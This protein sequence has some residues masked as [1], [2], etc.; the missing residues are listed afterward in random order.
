MLNRH[1]K[2]TVW[3]NRRR[4]NELSEFRELLVV[5]FN[6]IKF[7][8]ESHISRQARSKINLKVTS[9]RE[10]VRAADVNTDVQWT[11][12]TLSGVW[13]GNNDVLLNF[14]TLDSMN[15]SPQIALDLVERATGVYISNHSKSISRTINPIW[16]VFRSFDWFIRLPF[17]L[18][19]VAGFDTYRLE[20]SVWGLLIKINFVIFS[21]TA[22]LITILSFLGKSESSR[23]MLGALAVRDNHDKILTIL[24]QHEKVTHRMIKL[25]VPYAVYKPSGVP[26]L[27]DAPEHWELRRTKTLLAERSQKGFPDEPLLAATQSRGVVRKEQYE[28]RTVLALKDLHLLKLVRAGDFVISLRSFQGGIEYAREQGIISPAY[29]VLYAR[30]PNAHAYLAWLFKSRPYVENLT[31][32]VTG[33]RQGQNIDY[34]KLSRSYL[35]LPSLCEQRAIVRYL[36]YVDRRI[37]RYISRQAESSS[38]CWRKR[39]RPSSTRPSPRGLNPN[40]R[41]KP[42]GVEWLGDVPEHW[43]V[44]S[45]SNSS[46]VKQ[47]SKRIDPTNH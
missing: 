5:Y 42:S 20:E 19:N 13:S 24:T 46:I 32:H 7:R 8:R 11:S 33:I 41:L 37:R 23:T 17:V 26:W 2:I 15:I 6:N 40:V 47:Y 1:N 18:G 27:S 29:T 39:S 38:T 10:I 12:P 43:E 25:P 36:D 21:A 3:E 31:L 22:S 28:N 16:W 4:I 9:I 35:P 34:E 45:V 30:N 14:A 44:R